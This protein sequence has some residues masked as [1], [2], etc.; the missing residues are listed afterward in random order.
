M[1]EIDHAYREAAA[2]MPASRPVIE[3]TIPSSVDR[4]ISPPGQHVVQLFVQFAPYQLDSKVGNWADPAL[5][6]AFADRCFDIVEEFCP[7]F[8]ASV[9]GRDVVS[10]LD[11]ERI[12]GLHRGSISHGSLGLHQLGFT[13]P[14]SG[15]S[16]YRSPIKGLYMCGA[17]THPGGGVMGA[18]GRN[19]AKVVLS[20]LGRG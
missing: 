20:D 16:S 10:P 14:A 3:M 18:A 6:N 5:K 17:G 4:T 15:F 13:R 1:E 19:C 12:F 9:I 11:L 8:K 7:G 2:G